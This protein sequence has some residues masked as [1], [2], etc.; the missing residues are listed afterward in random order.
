[1]LLLRAGHR[2]LTYR[3]AACNHEWLVTEADAPPSRAADYPPG[4]VGT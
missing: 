3:C 4:R 2:T 1:M